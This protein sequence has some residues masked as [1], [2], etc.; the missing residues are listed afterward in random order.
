MR[1]MSNKKK[2]GII[3]FWE[4]NDNYGQQLQCWALQQVLIQMGCAPFL[5]RY[6]WT[7][8]KGSFKRIVKLKIKLFLADVLS[9]TKLD[10]IDALRKKLYGIYREET[11][12]RGFLKFRTKNL[13]QSRKIYYD[14]E[15]LKRNPPYADVY[16]TGSD[17]VWN[18]QKSSEALA[19]FFLQ[20]GNQDVRRISYAPSIAHT[21]Y[22]EKLLGTLRTYLS[23]FYAISVR[24]KSAMDICQ[25]VG[26]NAQV[27]VDPTI[28]LSP[29]KYLDIA[30]KVEP[31]ESIFIYSLNYSSEND[32][33]M[34]DICAYAKE[35][36]KSIIVTPS[37]GYIKGT[38]L[39]ANV[40]YEYSTI[41][42]WISRIAKASLVVTASFHGIVF[43]I[44]FHRPF[45]FTPLQG[46]Y[47]A[48]NARVF[49]LLD[50]LGLTFNV[51]NK[52]NDCSSIINQTID[53]SLVDAKIATLRKSSYHFLQTSI[54]G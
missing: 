5:I 48:G 4:S 2:I 47:S 35:T 17:Q 49:D 1:D 42:Q 20:F 26:F 9:V 39:F 11:I 23:S 21:S 29:Q 37:S 33:P 43:S 15:D 3:T 24:E 28:L 38:E 7:T 51:W 34:N 16:I 6:Q 27:V 41:P 30:S 25:S 12:Q 54:N 10:R 46:D 13:N 44:L 45:I 8:P 18:Y 53:W 31:E 32:V 36:G 40:Q 50:T 14:Y 19:A 52:D 22:P